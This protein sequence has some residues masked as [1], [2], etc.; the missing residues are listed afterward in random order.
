LF[1]AEPE[2]PARIFTA[3]DAFF[4]VTSVPFSPGAASRCFCRALKLITFFRH[5]QGDI[6][7]ITAAKR[8]NSLFILLAYYY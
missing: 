2:N 7:K 6:K 1:I 5:K 3:F 4:G 8:T